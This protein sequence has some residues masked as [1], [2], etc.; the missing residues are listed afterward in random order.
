LNGRLTAQGGSAANDLDDGFP[1]EIVRIDHYAACD[2]DGD[3]IRAEFAMIGSFV[4]FILAERHRVAA[5]I[6]SGTPAAALPGL[7]A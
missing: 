6:S 2:Y 5:H 4:F 3:C 7:S 1:L